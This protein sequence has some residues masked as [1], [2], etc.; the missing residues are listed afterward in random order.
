[1]LPTFHNALYLTFPFIQCGSNKNFGAIFFVMMM[2]SRT[3]GT[4][5]HEMATSGLELP[6]VQDESDI[7]MAISD[8][9]V[10]SDDE[11]DDDGRCVHF[12]EIFS[13]PRVQKHLPPGLI[14]CGAFDI[15]GGY[16]FCHLTGR[17]K[18]LFFVLNYKSC[19]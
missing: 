8:T 3:D 16:D 14:S 15:L 5:P 12:M 11:A 9:E 17:L 10:I 2:A 7:T 6:V 1:M 18:G 4:L 19:C 13:P